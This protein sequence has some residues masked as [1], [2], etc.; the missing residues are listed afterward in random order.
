[1]A[2]FIVYKIWHFKMYI[3]SRILITFILP[4]GSTLIASLAAYKL[5]DYYKSYTLYS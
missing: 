1:M 3:I 5:L 2:T 4:P